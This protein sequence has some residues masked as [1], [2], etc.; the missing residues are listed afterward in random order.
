MKLLNWLNDLKSP[1]SGEISE[2]ELAPAL[3]ARLGELENIP[4]QDV[5]IPRA[6]VTALDVDVQLKRVRRL[7]SSKPSYFPVYRGD[8]DRILGWVTK[9]KV[10]ELLNDRSEDSAL[11]AAIQ[12]VGEIHSTATA[13]DLADAF[14]IS[15]SPFLVVKNESRQTLGIVPLAEFI[16]LAFG[17]E[18]EAAITPPNLELVAPIDRPFEV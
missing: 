9:T 12:P 11:L 6:L 18:A 10:L 15:K 1:A 13:A 4:V 5:M 2:T 14:V 3:Q 7:K 8:L 17:F 16:E